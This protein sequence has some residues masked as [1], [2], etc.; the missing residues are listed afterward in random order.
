MIQ[1]QQIDPDSVHKYG[2]VI[3]GV[4][5]AIMP[6]DVQIGMIVQIALKD[7]VRP[8]AHDGRHSRLMAPYVQKVIVSHDECTT[9]AHDVENVNQTICPE[10]VES[11]GWDW[12][13]R[14]EKKFNKHG[15]AN[16]YSNYGCRCPEC[17]WAKKVRYGTGELS[18][19][20]V[21]RGRTH[22]PTTTAQ[23]TTSE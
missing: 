7:E 9:C 1:Y 3:D 19:K 22:S 23:S 2:L 8:S 14:F 16:I 6:E 10:C 18:E 12:L 17:R 4:Q 15:D 11:W 21:V 20:G 5:M 13:V